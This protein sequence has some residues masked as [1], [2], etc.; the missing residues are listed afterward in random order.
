MLALEASTFRSAHIVTVFS[1]CWHF[2]QSLCF[3]LSADKKEIDYEKGSIPLLGCE[4]EILKEFDD[5]GVKYRAVRL[6]P[7]GGNDVVIRGPSKLV[8]QWAFAV[9]ELVADAVSLSQ[10]VRARCSLICCRARRLELSKPRRQSH[11]CAGNVR[12][13]CVSRFF[14]H[15]GSCL[16]SGGWC[17]LLNFPTGDKR[18][19]K[20][21]SCGA[22]VK[23]AQEVKSQAKP[24]E[25]KPESKENKLLPARDREHRWPVAP[26]R[27]L[28]HSDGGKV[29]V[30][31]QFDDSEDPSTQQWRACAEDMQ[32]LLE[33]AFKSQQVRI[34][35]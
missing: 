12:S 15:A 34:A 20:C 24:A 33:T 3:K 6:T 2:V 29:K 1:R 5:R 31:W 18:R 10:H 23:D 4:C 7:K 8:L 19:E 26:A 35:D 25:P 21:E 13:C 28:M 11:R 27:P 9:Q 30:V 22:S 17:S 32:A 14:T 16:F